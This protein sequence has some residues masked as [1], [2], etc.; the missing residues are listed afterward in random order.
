MSDSTAPEP[1]ITS[2]EF[3][4]L[5]ESTEKTFNGWMERL[6]KNGPADVTAASEVAA[7]SARYNHLVAIK[8]GYLTR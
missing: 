4:N 6:T 3:D 7:A 5:I 2:S 1:R 8:R